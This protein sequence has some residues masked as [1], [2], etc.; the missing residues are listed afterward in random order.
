M[1]EV[2]LRLLVD[3]VRHGEL[4]RRHFVERMLGL[5]LTVPMAGMMLMQ[6]G[7]AGAQTEAPYKPARRGGGGTLRLLQSEAPTLLNP[8]FATGMKD[9]FGSRIFYE[10]LAQWDVDGNLEPVLAAEI[11]SRDNGGLAPDARSV[12]WMLKRDVT[13]ADGQPFTADDVI[14]NWQYAID[15]DTATVTAGGYRNLKM[16]KLDSHTVRVVFATPSP[17]WPGQYSQVMLVPRHLFAPFIG[18]KSR[19]APNNNR[20]V[21]TGAYT[22]VEFKPADLLRAVL[23]PRYHQANRPHF[24]ALEL[25][26]GGDSASAAR[27]V[28][29]TGEYDYAGSLVVE[30]DV[31]KRMEAGGKGRVQLLN[32]SATSAIYLNFADPGTEVDGERSNPKTR[33]PLFSDTRVR[34]AIGHLVDRQTMET[35][36]YGRFG[37]ATKNYINVPARYRSPNTSAEFNITKAAALLEAAEWKAGADGVR[38]KNGRKLTLLFQAAVNGLTQKVQAVFKQAA[39]KAG[40]Q[41]DLK[42]VVPSVFFSSDIG[43]TDTYGKFYADIQTYNWTNDSPDPEGLMQCFVSWEACSRANKWLGQNLVRWQN[44][45]FDALFRAAETELDAVKR[46]ALFIRMNDLVVGDG[47]VVPIIARKSARAMNNRLVAPLSGWQTD[48]ASL[49]HWYRESA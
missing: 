7:V 20:P 44:A 48:I 17:F 33:H 13:W 28:L 42:A 22:F 49:P 12:V 27:A 47:Y 15:P 41:I 19:D 38:E 25:K 24:D 2:E 37:V 43:N 35:Y 6:A 8:H 23:N 34:R 32:A 16:E 11:P 45:E 18:A 21:G 26:G 9:G 36:V 1:I 46:A 30:D 29:Q 40:I 5:G 14:F 4:T 31:L 10:P 3:R 39:Q